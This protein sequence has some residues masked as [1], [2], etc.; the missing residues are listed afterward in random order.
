[1]SQGDRAGADNGA[2][3]ADDR[4]RGRGVVGAD[5]GRRISSGL[6]GGSTPA[7]EWMAVTSS[8]WSSCR[9]GRRV[10]R[11]SARRVLPVPGG[12]SIQRLW[13]PAAQTSSARRATG[14]PAT[15]A[16]STVGPRRLGPAAGGSGRVLDG[17]SPGRVVSSARATPRA[18]AGRRPAP[19]SRRA[20]EPPPRRCGG[21]DHGDGSGVGGAQHGGEHASH[22]PHG[23]VEA[24]LTQE[25][26]LGDASAGTTPAA[27]RMATAIARSNWLPRL[28]RLAGNR[29]TVIRASGHG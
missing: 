29:L 28:G 11:R 16:R 6:S 15:S 19:P 17:R 14:W 12:P 2:A 5:E 25:E 22:R 9:A 26:R 21:D 27:P 20:P 4:R 1:M 13:L 10:G 24:Q 18:G 3:A 23:A 8:A 7:T